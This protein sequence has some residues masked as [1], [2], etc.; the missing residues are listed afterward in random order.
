MA[1]AAL[2]TDAA[3]L[4]EVVDALA[5]EP[6]YAVDTEFH[7]ERTYFPKVALTPAAP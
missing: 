5:G 1:E 6:A 2:V 7:R 4:A 3:G